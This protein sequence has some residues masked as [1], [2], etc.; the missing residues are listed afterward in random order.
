MSVDR[1]IADAHALPATEVVARLDSDAARGLSA[2]EA[3]ARL[4]KY[5]RNALPAAATVPAWRRFLA[6]FESPLVLLLL[7]AVAVSL[8]VWWVEGP[9][10]IPYEALTILAIVLANAVLGFVQEER[11]EAAVAALARLS[12]AVATVLRDGAPVSI[13]AAQLVPGDI[14]LLEEG[15]TIPADARVLESVSLRTAEAALTGESTPV[16]KDVAPAPQEAAL[17][18]RAGM[19][20]SGTAVTYGHGRAVVTA[21]AS[22]TEVGRIA[23]LLHATQAEQTPLQVQ[24]DRLGRTLGLV[25]IAIAIIVAATILGLHRDFSLVAL[26]GVLLYTVALAVS[27]VPEGLAAVTTVVLSLGMQRMARRNAI[28]RKLSAVE[29]LGSTTV[30]CSDKTGTLTRNE[31]TVRAVVT[32]S[33]RTEVTGT[34]YEPTGELLAGGA[35]LGNGDQRIEVERTLA[36]GFLANNAALVERDGRWAV[37]GDPTEAALK[38]A[39]LKAGLSAERLAQRFGRAGEIPFSSERKMMSTAHTDARHPEQLVLFSKGAPDVLLGCCARVRIGAAEQ[40]L[41]ALRRAAILASID[42]LAGEALRL[43]GCAYRRLA[44]AGAAALSD[45]AETELVWL[46]LVGMIDPPRPEAIAAVA[47]AQRAGVRVVMITGDH[48]VAAAAIAREIGIARPDERIVTGTELARMDAAELSAAAR[49]TAVYARVSPEHK[50]AIVRA[51]KAHGEIVA[52]TGD[53]VNDAPA[54]KAADIGIAMGITGTDVS[55]EAADM[56]LADDNFATI[57]AA[58]EEGRSI[59]ANIRKFLRYLLATNLGEVFV[60]FFGVVLAG[61]LGIAAGPGEALVLPLLATMILWINLVTDSAPALALGV[62]PADPGLMLRAPRRAT[63]GAI[64]RSMWRQIAVIST[65][66]GVVTL[67]VLDAGLPGGL[68]EGSGE[69]A[70]ARTMAFHTLVLAQL[71]A[72]VGVRSETA[73]VIHG[74]CSNLWIW[75]AIALAL[76]LQLLVLYVPALQ[77]GFG[78]VALGSGDWLVCTLA[79]ATVLLALEAAKLLLRAA[80]QTPNARSTPK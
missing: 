48:P 41:D 56:I 17:A 42:A 13:P 31:M 57:V 36:V 47:V 23:G 59:Y 54:L 78:T 67:L 45:G 10:G 70:R 63:E 43:I 79:A 25:V 8:L 9:H 46:G 22:A 4:A 38:A 55:K 27:A 21:T 76:A 62:D 39:A 51:L 33:G 32:A 44:D 16:A 35:A 50:L 6:Q 40:P 72:V 26:T 66:T 37:H 20:Y 60:L 18:D 5:G 75:S 1:P 2:A 53:G 64:S 68:I 12:A 61:A 14:L 19:L 11:A 49:E 24:L 80:P 69:I 34:G 28:V 29:T 3:R 52:M 77:R 7:A 30:I 65:V 73:S 74:L 58:I 15:A 71:F